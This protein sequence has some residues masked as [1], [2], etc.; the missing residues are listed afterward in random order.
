MCVHYAY[1]LLILKEIQ[2]S[3]EKL[4]T[5]EHKFYLQTEYLQFNVHKKVY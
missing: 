3:I 4:E 1:V 2:R 5:K